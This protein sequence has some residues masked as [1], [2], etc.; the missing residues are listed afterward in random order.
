MRPPTKKKLATLFFLL[1]LTVGLVACG[2]KA[3]ASHSL[4]SSALTGTEAM[5]GASSAAQDPSA[6]AA[7]QPHTLPAGTFHLYNAERYPDERAPHVA[8]QEGSRC[9]LQVHSG[10]KIG[11][12]EAD[13]TIDGST[14]TLSIESVD[15]DDSFWGQEQNTV[16][17]QILD[18]DNLMLLNEA[19]GL[20][21]GGDVF[22]REGATPA[23]APDDAP[24]APPATEKPPQ[25]SG[26]VSEAPASQSD[27]HSESDAPPASS[28][29]SDVS[30]LSSSAA[31]PPNK[32]GKIGLPFVLAICA[33]AAAA[34]GLVTFIAVR[35]TRKPPIEDDFAV[36]EDGDV[37]APSAADKQTEHS[38]DEQDTAPTSRSA[39]KLRRQQKKAERTAKKEK[40]KAEKA[41]A[42][43]EKAAAKAAKAQE[44]I[45]ALQ[46]T[47]DTPDDDDSPPA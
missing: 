33:L 36:S 40:R 29:A 31:E 45:K 14:L 34:G 35:A 10:L 25:S 47:S 19:Y 27:S 26:T 24:A 38:N 15:I 11:T 42:K 8:L 28:A 43:S 2:G 30:R 39:R 7:P 18:D 3:D 16:S 20:A 46:E 17:F 44:K 4:S 22:T 32:D 21:F 41:T 9:R 37:S 23:K 5:D 12:A 13:Y 1:I 6:S